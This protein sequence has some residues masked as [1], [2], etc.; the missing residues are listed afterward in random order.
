MLPLNCIAYRRQTAFHPP[1]TKRVW[2]LTKSAAGLAKNNAASKLSS[3][4]AN[5]PSLMRLGKSTLIKSISGLTR[6][7]SGEI[8]FE[9]KP[10]QGRAPEDIVA[11]GIIQVPQGR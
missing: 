6:V 9:G 7:H 8:L 10:I 3:G 1:S 5:R 11:R 4:F 2:P